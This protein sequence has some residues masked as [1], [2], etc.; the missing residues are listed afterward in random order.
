MKFSPLDNSTNQEYKNCLLKSEFTI[1]S[2]LYPHVLNAY[3][4]LIHIQR[5]DYKGI[6]FHK[7]NYDNEEV[8]YPP[9]GKCSDYKK[10]FKKLIPHN[11]TIVAIPEDMML[12]LKEELGDSIT[13][14]YED[15]LDDYIIDNFQLSTLTGR[16]YNSIRQAVNR[17]TKRYT[18]S[19]IN[20]KELNKADILSF[21]RNALN[22][23]KAASNDVSGP[24]KEGMISTLLIEDYYN[25]PD[26][27]I[28]T[29]IIADN[30]IVAFSINEILNDISAGI[31]LKCDRNY[32]SSGTF[33]SVMDAKMQL[34]KGIRYCNIMADEG[35]EQLKRSKLLLR[36]CRIIRKYRGYYM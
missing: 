9:I 7:D 18:P 22:Q 32:P 31:Y 5:A 12:V 25:N 33:L 10:L 23:L 26:D 2:D 3:K 14:T 11:S 21:N 36:P 13:F 20:L 35:D 34:E 1:P 15:F 28:G 29:A 6:Y 17:F 4:D 8:W 16:K 30:S 27:F 19:V 24:I